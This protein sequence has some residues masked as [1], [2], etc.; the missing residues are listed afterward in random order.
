MN[1]NKKEKHIS[2]PE[3]LHTRLRILAKKS[4]R[5]MRGVLAHL[6]SKEEKELKELKQ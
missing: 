2:V 1:L 6:I 4:D 3:G 5:T